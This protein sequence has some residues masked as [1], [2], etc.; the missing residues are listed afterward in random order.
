MSD[1]DSAPKAAAS[2]APGAGKEKSYD[3]MEPFRA[4]RDT[5]LNVMSKNMMET[6]NSEAYAQATGTM[7]ESYLNV[8]APV[9]DALDKSMLQALEQLSLPSRQDVISLAERFTNMEMRLDDLDAK[10][11]EVLKAVRASSAPAAAPAG[12]ASKGST[13]EATE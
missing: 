10:L 7:L 8:A 12:A 11:D 3:P 5:Y 9:K 1:G 4:W 6:V 13:A 2:G